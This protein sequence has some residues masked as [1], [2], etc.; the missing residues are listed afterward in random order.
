MRWR[1]RKVNAEC[2]E[3]LATFPPTLFD[4]LKSSREYIRCGVFVWHIICAAPLARRDAWTTH[5][6]SSLIYFLSASLI[7]CS[8]FFFICFLSLCL[9][10]LVMEWNLSFGTT[11]LAF[12]RTRAHQFFS[13]LLF[14]YSISLYFQQSFFCLCHWC[15]GCHRWHR[16]HRRW[17][18]PMVDVTH[19]MRSEQRPNRYC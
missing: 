2:T 3:E 12:S 16:W 15:C 18:L 11:V 13:E 4:S 1:H 19:T 9:F 7:Y 8:R 14:L 10:P 17:S 6:F 5:F